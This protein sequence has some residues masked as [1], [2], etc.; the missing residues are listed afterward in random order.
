M[1]RKEGRQ[2]GREEGDHTDNNNGI[3]KGFFGDVLKEEQALAD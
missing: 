1:E 3:R 2:G